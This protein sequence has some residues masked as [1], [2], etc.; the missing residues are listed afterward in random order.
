MIT[1]QNGTL[2]ITYT[3][4]PTKVNRILSLCSESL[5]PHYPI[6]NAEDVVIPF[7]SLTN[8]QKLDVI[9]KHVKRVLMDSAKSFAVNSA[10]NIAR[11]GAESEDL[12]L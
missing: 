4:T 5:Y 9:D 8:A 1:V 7:A 2:T 6:Y 3:G 10:M 11:T 12:T